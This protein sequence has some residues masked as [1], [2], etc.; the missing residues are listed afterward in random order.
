[1]KIDLRG[2]TAIVTGGSRGI[3]R[4]VVR[5]LAQAGADV[6]V[7]A[8]TADRAEAAS[9]EAAGFGVR[10]RPYGAD[11][12]DGKAVEALVGSVV[13]EFG[14]LHI[15]VNN[16][17][18]A[19][20]ALLLRMREE[21]F[22]RV[23]EVNLK[24]AFHFCRAALRPM[25]KGGFGRILNV[26]SVVGLIG[27]PGQTNYAASKAGLIGFT[28][29]LAKEVASRGITVNALAPGLIETDMT[30]GLGAAR[31]EILARVPLGRLGRPEEVASAVLFLASPEA[32]Y[33]TGTVLRVDGGLGL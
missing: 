24:G 16:A 14:G 32:S 3:G 9:R 26:A 29:S 8:T 27:N 6:A 13:S 23:L 30:S 20:D 10:A 11:V 18:I 22:D 33:V 2:K 25:L 31:E 5:A 17:G 12:A 28:N 19:R 7:V 21:D 1:V 4:A 15:L